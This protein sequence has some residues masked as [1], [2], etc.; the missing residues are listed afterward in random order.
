[1]A[2]PVKRVR[3]FVASPGDVS[4]EREQLSKVIQEINQTISAIAP[5]KSIFL[6]LVKWE[7]HVHPGLGRDAQDVVNRQIGD[8]DI[9]LGIM[10][11]RFGSPTSVAA[12]GTEEEF[13][14]A[15][16]RWEQNKK[17]PILFYFS[18]APSAPPRSKEEA[19]QLARVVGF[20]EELSEKGLIWDYQ[21][22]RSFPDTVRPHLIQVLSQMFS[23][24]ESPVAAAQETSKRVTEGDLSAI[25]KQVSALAREYE[26]L[27]E[28]MPSGYERTRMMSIV[29]SRMRTLAL[30]AFPLLAELVHSASPGDRLAAV[31]ILKQI[32]SPDYLTWLANRVGVEKPFIG[33]QATVALLNAGRR[34]DPPRDDVAR[35]VEMAIDIMNNLAFKD[36]NQL[37]TLASARKELRE[38]RAAQ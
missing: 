26:Q 4:V 21:E 20:K 35:A 23:G 11:R 22:P 36:P 24:K 1:M 34:L 2:D 33:Y 37:R 7:T 28:T 5:E 8:Y 25:R 13:R 29:E 3:V 31:A 38:A 14:R 10:W 27:R 16:A 15:Y 18:Q 17:L 30:S 19:D 32:P 12:S 9:F 6:E